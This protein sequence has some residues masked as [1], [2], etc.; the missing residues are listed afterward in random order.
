MGPRMFEIDT[1]MSRLESRRL[2]Q[3][4]FTRAV[5]E[6]CSRG[7]YPPHAVVVEDTDNGQ[8]QEQAFDRVH[9]IGQQRPVHIYKLVVQD[10][11][12]EQILKVCIQYALH[13]AVLSHLRSFRI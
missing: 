2:Q 9:R 5:V 8:K 3:C 10:T 12:E 13:L 1:N 11:I 7:K 4:H 6:P